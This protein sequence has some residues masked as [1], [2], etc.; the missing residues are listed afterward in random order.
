MSR[1]ELEPNCPL[2]L[3]W[4]EADAL[5]RRAVEQIVHGWLDESEREFGLVR[6]HADEVGVEEILAELQSGSLMAPRRVVVVDSINA[7]LNLHQRKLAPH[8]A[9]LQPGLAVVLVCARQNDP[10]RG[11]PVAA[12]LRKAVQAGGQVIEIRP[13]RERELPGWI[14]RE[15]QAQG[16]RIDREAVDALCATVGADA[17]RLLSEIEK[18]ATYVGEREQVTAADVAEV[19]VR[20]SEADIFKIVDAIGLKDARA[21]LTML[22]GVLLEEPSSGDCIAFIGMVTR[23]LR[24]IWQARFVRQRR[25]R[26]GDTGGA[27]QEVASRLPEHHNFMDAV[28]GKKWLAEALTRQAAR[29]SDG[30]LARAFDRAHQADVALKGKGARLE[31]RTVV[32][33][34]IVDLCR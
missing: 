30:Q 12:E 23:Q 8:L 10:R 34:L 6:V 24:L 19:S 18:L 9:R 25:V 17:D 31:P 11:V 16:K 22:D 13:P 21:A 3:L 20:V 7:L 14:A 32:E 1:R 29:F 33:L 15:M 4:G 2:T 5:K 27:A 26:P 28:K